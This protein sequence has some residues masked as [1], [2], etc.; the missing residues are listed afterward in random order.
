MSSTRFRGWAWGA[1]AGWMAL[2]IAPRAQAYEPHSHQQIVNLA[3]QVM[4][5]TA[6][7]QNLQHTGLSVA[8]VRDAPASCSLCGSEFS[9]QDWADFVERVEGAIP[10]LGELT[11]SIGGSVNCGITGAFLSEVGQTP[12]HEHHFSLEDESERKCQLDN[13]PVFTPRGIYTTLEN[14]ADGTKRQGMILGWHAK[15][16]DDNQVESTPE[17]T[18][19]AQAE[20]TVVGESLTFAAEAFLAILIVPFVCGWH[21]ITGSD[22]NCWD[23]TRDAAQSINPADDILDAFFPDIPL[24]SDGD[25]VGLWHFIHAGPPAL[26]G[27]IAQVTELLQDQQPDAYDDR[28]GLFYPLAGP[29]ASPGIIDYAIMTGA[30]VSGATVVFEESLGA[31]RYM[32]NGA[33]G[34]QATKVRGNDDW[35]LYSLATTQFSPIDNLARFGWDHFKSD[36]I[37]AHNAKWLKWPLHALGDATVP[38]HVVGTTGWGH[39]PYETAMV[40]VFDRVRLLECRQ[41]LDEVCGPELEYEQAR[42]IAQEAFRWLKFIDAFRATAGDP[43][44]IPVRDLVTEVAKETADFAAGAD[45]YCDTCSAAFAL[46]GK[47]D[48]LAACAASTVACITYEAAIQPI[49]EKLFP[50]STNPDQLFDASE[51]F[52]VNSK[53]RV[54]QMRRLVEKSAAAKLAFLVALA[55][56][57]PD[58]RSNGRACDDGSQCCSTFCDMTQTAASGLP[59]VCADDPQCIPFGGSCSQTSDCCNPHLVTCIDG[60]C[61][62]PPN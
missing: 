61:K 16:M 2:A 57:L 28:M 27:A 41:D 9:A 36:P 34:H 23:A 51:G 1:I 17:T 48:D 54:D 4:R 33:D 46:G 39:R 59:G 45:L 8:D 37:F 13:A 50:G 47:E 52:Y 31:Q 5:L 60:T 24:G 12:L 42:R 6:D 3:W 40:E 32:P 43:N 62:I 15:H 20:N 19:S 11:P 21:L 22:T 30:M 29:N 7:P 58:C 35:E 49:A 10:R 55:D 38:M 53:S 25:F 26:P 14:N 44:D 56:R 18:M